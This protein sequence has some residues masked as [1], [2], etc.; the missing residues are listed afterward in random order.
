MMLV[1]MTIE[2]TIETTIEV[3]LDPDHN[4]KMKE[5][6][7]IATRTDHNGHHHQEVHLYHSQPENPNQNLAHTHVTTV[8]NLA[9]FLQIAQTLEDK[10]HHQQKD[11]STLLKTLGIN[12]KWKSQITTNRLTSWSKRLKDPL[13]P[14]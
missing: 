5:D 3:T 12:N 11:K 8:E 10:T 14:H 4:I 6:E 7:I 9:I 13:K 1:E 2:M